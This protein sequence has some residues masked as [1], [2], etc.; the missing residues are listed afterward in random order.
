MLA[1]L[2][3]LPLVRIGVD[4][5]MI[6]PREARAVEAL[7]DRVAD[8]EFDTGDRP[9]RLHGDLWSGNLMWSP[10][11]AVLI[12]PAA[13]G[14]HREADLALL[15]LFGAPMLDE[16]LAGYQEQAPLADGWQERVPLHQLHPVLLHL[17]LF[18]RG[19]AAELDAI[20]RTYA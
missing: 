19:Y 9:A 10:T 20:L 13:H 11:G 6:D 4:R 16:I 17:V 14:G 7:A 2:R 3:L 5:R 18:G 12:D 8:G 1:E 15:A